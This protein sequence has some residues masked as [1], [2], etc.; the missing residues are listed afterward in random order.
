MKKLLPPA[1]LALFAMSIMAPG[2][3][4]AKMSD[5]DRAASMVLSSPRVKDFSA[6]MATLKQKVQ[7]I[8]ERKSKCMFNVHVFE[9]HP[10]HI[11][12]FGFFN[13]DICRGKVV[14]EE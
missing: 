2:P 3:T 14:E 8:A 4:L 5:E 7:V 1:A 12:T 13:A 10:D 9:D 11:A 6:R